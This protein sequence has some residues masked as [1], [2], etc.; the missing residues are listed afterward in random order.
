ME[1]ANNSTKELTEVFEQFTSGLNFSKTLVPVKL[2]QIEGF[3]LMSRSQAKRLVTR[4]EKFSDVLLDFKDV[5]IVGQGFADQLFRVFKNE[6]PNV[7]LIPIN[8]SEDVE[9]MVRHVGG[10]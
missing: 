8:M 1:I 5:Q 4:F 10:I 2:A 7:N 3:T 6:H 9:F